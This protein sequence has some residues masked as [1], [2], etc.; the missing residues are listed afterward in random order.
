[1]KK[2]QCELKKY[3]YLFA[4]F[5]MPVLF[6]ATFYSLIKIYPFGDN[7]ILFI[8]MNA[9]Y[10]AFFEALRDA[11]CGEGSLVYSWGRTLGGE[12]LGIYSYYLMSP[13]SYIVALFSE[14][15][16]TLAILIITLIKSG[17]SG[18]TMAFFLKNSAPNINKNATLLFSTMYALCSY[19]VV[20]V[21]NTMWIDALIWLPLVIYGLEQIFY[22][23]KYGIFIIA[24]SMSIV[25]NFYTGYMICLFVI[26]YYFYLLIKDDTL[27]QYN[28]KKEFFFGTFIR[29][30]LASIAAVLISCIALIPACYGLSF[31]K[32]E[33]SNP[34]WMPSIYCGFKDFVKGFLACSENSV[35]S[36]G[37]PY[38]YCGLLPIILLLFSFLSNTLSKRE[39]IA[40]A[41]LI[42]GLSLTFFVSTFQ[43]IIHCGQY[44]VWFNYRYSFMLPFVIILISHNNF[45]DFYKI[46]RW[47]IILVGVLFA[48]I[49][50]IV[51]LLD[52]NITALFINLFIILS[53]TIGILIIKSCKKNIK[54]IGKFIVISAVIFDMILSGM[55]N[56]ALSR[57][58]ATAQKQSDFEKTTYVMNYA[59]DYITQYDNGFYRFDKTFLRSCNDNVEYGFR[60]VSGSTSTLNSGALNFVRDLGYGQIQHYSQ[61][62][63]GSPIVSD[64][65]TGIKY[66]VSDQLLDNSLY[67]LVMKDSNNNI[68]VYKNPFA[69]S[70]GYAANEKIKNYKSNSSLHTCE[71]INELVSALTGD[72]VLMFK[73]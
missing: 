24:L 51:C 39:K 58:I 72:N 13:L 25:S 10:V 20:Y 19:S 69:L 62:M 37:T 55:C 73:K 49:T 67:E 22:K 38:L 52:E 66:I 50:S 27:N 18:A 46:S 33:F 56:M 34:N 32:T 12:F 3:T 54:A 44:P 9:Q 17:L 31:G 15:K 29:I 7:T 5:L 43:L 1:M 63:A 6:L 21:S 60:G 23:K 68:Y 45:Y 11:I 65:L 35:N 4:A 48:I 28:T 30:A 42:G 71:K 57:D 59:V 8:D 64:S 16:I 14:E 61:Y 26:M 40:N 41:F 36:V 70:I 53:I 2:I 47:K